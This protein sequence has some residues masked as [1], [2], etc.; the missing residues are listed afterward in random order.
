MRRLSLFA[1]CLVCLTSGCTMFEWV[2][3]HQL[4]KLNR[5]PA[6]S[7][8][9]AYFNIPAQPVVNENKTAPGEKSVR[10]F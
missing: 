10:P 8:D 6:M 5:Q 4:W 3:P 1:T 7:R 2:R 9:D